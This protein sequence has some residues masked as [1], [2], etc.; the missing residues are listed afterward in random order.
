[1][2]K[3]FLT[4]ALI[5]LFASGVAL[6]VIVA[7]NTEP[8]PFSVAGAS[9]MTA[10]EVVG[11]SY[12]VAPYML[13]KIYNA[14]E[15]SEEEAIYD[16]LA[17]VAA[18]DALAQLYLERVG[19]LAGGGLEADQTLHAM[20][21]LNLEA[22]QDGENAVLV[23]A[24]WRVVGTVG[25]NKHMHIRG[26]SYSAYLQLQPVDGT[27]Q[28]T[29]FDLTDVDRSEAGQTRREGSTDDWEAAQ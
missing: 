11:N 18:D 14:F 22:R 3:I 1:M 25:H 24:T 20:D 13:V 16:T 23:D 27:W 9:P 10:P 8:M 5:V 26:N 7:S 15:Q 17:E 12:A 29:G 4:A 28:M 2:N 21:I 6:T 19:A